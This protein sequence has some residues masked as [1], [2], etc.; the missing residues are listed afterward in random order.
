MWYDKKPLGKFNKCPIVDYYVP[1]WLLVLMGYYIVVRIMVKKSV[2][3]W[4][5]EENKKYISR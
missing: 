2:A 1:S 3:A 4:G 5:G